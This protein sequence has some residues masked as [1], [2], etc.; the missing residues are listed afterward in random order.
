MELAKRVRHQQPPLCFFVCRSS[1]QIW[2][3]LGGNFALAAAS[4]CQKNLLAYFVG[5]PY[6]GTRKTQI[7]QEI[8]YRNYHW[9]PSTSKISL[10]YFV[11]SWAEPSASAHSEA[12]HKK[13]SPISLRSSM[14]LGEVGSRPFVFWFASTCVTGPTH[15]TISS[16]SIIRW[17]VEVCDQLYLYLCQRLEVF[18]RCHTNTAV[19]VL[20]NVA[21]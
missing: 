19:V 12:Y 2:A 6:K 1:G 3:N 5:E 4:G 10:L 16:T 18:S 13:S 7:T 15:R 9:L 17:D 14:C 20:M 8:I 11:K 21:F